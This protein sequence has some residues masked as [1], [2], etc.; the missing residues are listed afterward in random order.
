[1]K[2]VYVSPIIEKEIFATADVITVSVTF[3]DNTYDYENGTGMKE[4]NVKDNYFNN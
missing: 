2:K 3:L 1:M 4:I